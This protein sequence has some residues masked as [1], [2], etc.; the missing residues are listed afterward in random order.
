V[1]PGFI[2]FDPLGVYLDATAGNLA[3]ILLGWA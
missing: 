3:N 1:L 2:G